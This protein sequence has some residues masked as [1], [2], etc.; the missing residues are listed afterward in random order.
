MGA[1]RERA[2]DLI[3]DMNGNHVVQRCLA[4]L[5]TAQSTFIFERVASDLLAVATH[6]HGCCVA[7]RSLDHADGP[8]RE[9]IIAEVVRHAAK[10]VMD[11]FGNYVV[12]Y[13]LQL[14]QPQLTLAV[15]TALQGGFAELSLQKFSSNVI[16]KCLKSGDK[17]VVSMVARELTAAR[18]LGTLLHDPFANYVLQT[19]LTVG[20]DEEVA[21]FVEK[22]QPYL[23][24]LRSTLYG[25]RIQAKLFRRCPK[26]R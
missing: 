24:N 25:K 10:L 7:Q 1:L 21:L 3:R 13:I 22:I 2:M 4:S 26:L 9:A 18:T 11:P 19:L 8:H 12:Q 14:K 17:R 20:S 16:E 6:R 15:A 23:S 5:P